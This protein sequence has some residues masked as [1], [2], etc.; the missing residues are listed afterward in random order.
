MSHFPQTIGFN[1]IDHKEFDVDQYTSNSSKGCVL[2]V[3]LEY[4]QEL[5]KLCNDYALAPDKI[6]IKREML[7]Q[8]QLNIGDLYNITIDNVKKIVPNFF[9]K[10]KYV[11]QYENL[12]LYLRLVLKLK[13][14]AH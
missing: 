5:Q 10:E 3:N 4:P 1:W 12:Q 7:S 11:L 13:N 14:I 6:K 2:Q 8:Y 9:G